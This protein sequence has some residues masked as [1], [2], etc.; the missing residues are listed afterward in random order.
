MIRLLISAILFAQLNL[1]SSAFAET[2]SAPT[3]LAMRHQSGHLVIAFPGLNSPD[4]ANTRILIDFDGT[5]SGE[6]NTGAD[7][8]IERGSIYS[9]IPQAS[10]W[11]W[12]RI[13]D[14]AISQHKGSAYVVALEK[15]PS[16][17]GIF[18]VDPHTDI[19]PSPGRLNQLKRIPFNLAD[20]P[21]WPDDC[22]PGPYPIESWTLPVP[23]SLS[24]RLK[25]EV[26]NAAWEEVTDPWS[27]SWSASSTSTQ[28][29]PLIIELINPLSGIVDRISGGSIL[30]NGTTTRWFGGINDVNWTLLFKPMDTGGLEI[31]GHFV[32]E[33][34]RPIRVRIGLHVDMQGWQWH[35]ALDSARPITLPGEPYAQLADQSL[36]D[37]DYSLLPFGVISS[38]N[39]ALT[40]ENNPSEPRQFRIE[41]IPTHNFFG[42]TYDMALTRLTTKFPGQA[43]IQCAF[44]S[45]NPETPAQAMRKALADFYSRHPDIYENRIGHS[46]TWR[47]FPDTTENG[48]SQSDI[49]Y[50]SVWEAGFDIPVRQ[51]SSRLN[52]LYT[53][54]WYHWLPLPPTEPRTENAAWSRLSLMATSGKALPHQLAAATIG[55]I[56]RS[57]DNH[58][59]MQF[60][61]VP[62]NNGV[63]GTVSAD[64]DIPTNKISPVNRAMIESSVIDHHTAENGWDGVFLDSMGEWPNPDFSLNALAAADYPA[65]FNLATEQPFVPGVLSA[66]D[67]LRVLHFRTRSRGQFVFGNEAVA[68]GSWFIS[69]LDAFTQEANML[70]DLWMEKVSGQKAQTSRILAGAK[71]YSMGL[72]ANFANLSSHELETFL[73][74]CIPYGF[75]PGLHSA[76]GYDQLYWRNS[77]WL[78]RDRTLLDKYLPVIQRLSNAGWK[79]VSNARCINPEV[80]LES[81]GPDGTTSLYTLHNTSDAAVNA[82]IELPASLEDEIVLYP[83]SGRV[84]LR[85][86]GSAAPIECRLGPGGISVLSV[87]P[88]GHI[89]EELAHYTSEHIAHFNLSH[90][91]N[92]LQRGLNVTLEYDNPLIRNKDTQLSVIFQNTG[93]NSLAITNVTVR[94][95]AAWKKSRTAAFS[96]SPGE[97]Y[98]AFIALSSKDIKNDPQLHASWTCVNPEGSIDLSRL[99]QPEYTDPVSI[100]VNPENVI[101]VESVAAIDVTMVNYQSSFHEY[102]LITKGDTLFGE[103]NPHVPLEPDSQRTHRILVPNGGAMNQDIELAVKDDKKTIYRKNISIRYLPAGTSLLRDTRVQ[104]LTS[105][106]ADGF[107]SSALHDGI[108]DLSGL[109]W[110][111]GSW[112][113]IDRL[114]SHKVTIKFPQPVII[115]E[116]LLHWG[117]DARQPRP[118]V[119]GI[120][121][122]KLADD[123]Y[124]VLN[125]FAPD[126]SDSITRLS[127]ESIQVSELEIIQPPVS[128]SSM[129]PLAMWLAEI[130]V[131]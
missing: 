89:N 56:A 74:Q 42:I 76:D 105:G 97:S 10:D 16:M 108:T 83:L 101:S 21:P 52:F 69:K 122:A 94:G 115:S 2:I 13:G 6:P 66:Y 45:T 73:Q 43:T 44:H 82:L 127:F 99:I 107:K 27:P 7:W 37:T 47:P 93:T 12:S 58:P 123:H 90:I 104:V 120:V 96:L 117:M 55:G 38:S 3:A 128:G 50:F 49:E 72:I 103:T 109:L 81:F 77:A 25:D 35:D 24:V 23:S 14:A 5:Q 86:A 18:L 116:V 124:A 48:S 39:L 126:R 85:E 78:K 65:L 32:S 102:T 100:M 36:N 57:A 91:R 15:C 71:P 75:V 111:E 131:F 84:L 118:P 20:L 54:P 113:S 125:R 110:N 41:A 31:T 121:R 63:R 92:E 40:A 64:P 130:E 11:A 26:N 129:H 28:T 51:R 79:P 4:A 1:A 112:M 70:D 98:T 67:W 29:F 34:E 119:S 106:T 8:M 33:L 62:W 95:S 88:S 59:A 61:Q 68:S 22:V 53:E 60:I 30:R 46:G 80:R 17:Q 9:F 19:L 114:G 87:F